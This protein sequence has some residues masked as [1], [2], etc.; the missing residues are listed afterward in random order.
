MGSRVYTEMMIRRKK[1]TASANNINGGSGCSMIGWNPSL[2][3]KCFKNR[4]KVG[5]K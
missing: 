2:P 3:V 4:T 1:N 5:E